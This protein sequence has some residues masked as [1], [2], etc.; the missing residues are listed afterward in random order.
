MSHFSAKAPCLLAGP[1]GAWRSPALWRRRPGSRHLGWHSAPPGVSSLLPG[2][3]GGAGG[4]GTDSATLESGGAGSEPRSVPKGAL[5]C[6]RLLSTPCPSFSKRAPGCT[7]SRSWP[8]WLNRNTRALLARPWGQDLSRPQPAGPGPFLQ[9]PQPLVSPAGRAILRG[10]GA[11]GDTAERRPGRRGA[12]AGG[13]A[14]GAGPS[15]PEALPSPR[16]S[17]SCEPA[18]FPA[19]AVCRHWPGPLRRSEP[20]S[21]AAVHPH[22]PE[23][24]TEAW[25]PQGEGGGREW[26]GSPPTSDCR[27]RAYAARASLSGMGRGPSEERGRETGLWGEG[28]AVRAGS[29]GAGGPVLE[30]EACWDPALTPRASLLAARPPAS[31]RG[32]WA[33]IPGCTGFLEPSCSLLWGWPHLAAVV[34]PAGREET[35]TPEL[36]GHAHLCLL[37]G[38]EVRRGSGGNAKARFE[39]ERKVGT[40]NARENRTIS[41]PERS[42]RPHVLPKV[43][44]EGRVGGEP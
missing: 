38:P 34:R 37:E 43:V 24:E 4:S 6:P 30:T 10:K 25:R 44:P 19:V 11:E 27:I 31:I 20:R 1:C 29:S 7:P 2:N 5:R 14:G 8:L 39:Q 32:A 9:L 21:L 18:L 41:R 16:V 12:A 17:R 13:S 35:G 26:G 28:V 3:G 36:I 22:Y 40:W 42:G 33:H 15:A 23:E